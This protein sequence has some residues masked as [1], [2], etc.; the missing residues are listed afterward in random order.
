MKV[1]TRK[2][3]QA[4]ETVNAGSTS[5][6]TEGAPKE[7]PRSLWPMRVIRRIGTLETGI[8]VA[9]VLGILALWTLVTS[10]KL[11]DTTLLPSPWGLVSRFAE[12]IENGYQG[13][14]LAGHV[15]ISL[16]RA[17]LGFF[18]GTLVGVPLGLLMGSNSK[19]RAVFG[20]IFSF[21]RP[22][23]PIAF[24]PIVVLYFGLGETGKVVL[25]AVTSLNYVTVN[26]MAGADT[27]SISLKRAA[28]VLGLNRW[29]YLTTVVVP[30]AAPN[31]M[32]GLKVAM[33]LSWAVV[34]AAE[35]VGAQK[36]LGYIAS[37]AA[38]VFQV[39]DVF[40]SVILI[41]LIGLTLDR[42]LTWTDARLIHWR[43]R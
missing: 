16:Q 8:S 13:T 36:G 24:I 7:V 31:I 18:I 21:A 1:L 19:V 41:G 4:R 14:S 34:V 17:L 22:I 3:R 12:L 20:P 33:A 23:P 25:I 40:I 28:G 29:Q 6:D 35:L 30:S 2:L 26:A 37:S 5:P 39:G 43:G 38:L 27:V 42:L 9:T 15:L 11:V 32:T 10:L